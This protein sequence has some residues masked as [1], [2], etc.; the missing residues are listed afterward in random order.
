MQA[1]VVGAAF[2]QRRR[3]R[4]A[5][6]LLQRGQILEEDL[7]LEILG[8]GGDQHAMA[9]QDRRDQIRERLSRAGSRFGQQRPAGFDDRRDRLGHA[10]LAVA[11]LVAVEDAGERAALG[12]DLA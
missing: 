12:K 6:R 5:E 8:A 2:H 10:P 11:R 7:L 4:D 9:A 1:Q 3:E